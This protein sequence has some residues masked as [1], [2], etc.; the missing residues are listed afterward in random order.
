MNAPPTTMFSVPQ[1]NI[2]K[3]FVRHVKILKGV[4][5]ILARITQQG[6]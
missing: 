5:K 6:N 3:S 2:G 4:V 1:R